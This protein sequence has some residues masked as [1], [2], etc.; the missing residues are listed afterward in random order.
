MIHKIVT[1]TQLRVHVSKTMSLRL[2]SS[3]M[4]LKFKRPFNQRDS[5]NKIQ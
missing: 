2:P 4:E 5:F 3:V 1:I